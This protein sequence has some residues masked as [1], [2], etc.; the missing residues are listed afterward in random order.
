MF[1]NRSQIKPEKSD[2]ID[3]PTVRHN[4]E[5]KVLGRR[6]S[7]TLGTSSLDM[8]LV[9]CAL[10]II[11]SYHLLL[12][13]RILRRPSTT[14]IGHEN[15]NTLAWLRRAASTPEE[16]A[17]AVSVIADGV[18]A[19][20]N[21]AS[22][23]LALPS[24]IGAW[25]LSGT[26]AEAIPGDGGEDTSQVTATV[27]YASLIA[28][29]LASFTCFVQSAG[30][31]VHAS[32]LVSALASDAPVSH[33]QRAVLLGAGFWEAGLRALHLATA[34]L[35]WVAFGPAPMLACSV[36]TVAVLYLL[37]SSSMPLPTALAPVHA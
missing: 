11:L 34:I 9:P 26:S 15:H 12:Y 1:R 23:C 24:F 13:R 20:T 32:F 31:Y 17:M 19:S 3:R 27:K 35:V 37:D 30:C 29:F 33:V 7:M 16:A 21:L 28:C 8:V 14:V 25:A 22:L 4:V 18:S 6:K 36:L 10:V 2:E 5:E